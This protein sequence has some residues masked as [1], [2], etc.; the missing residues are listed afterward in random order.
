MANSVADSSPISSLL[1]AAAYVNPNAG[2]GR[3]LS[4]LPQIRKVF[5]AASVPAEFISVGSAKDLEL[6]SLGAIQNGKRLL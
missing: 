2:S 4:C 3:T 1:P 6:N 5:E